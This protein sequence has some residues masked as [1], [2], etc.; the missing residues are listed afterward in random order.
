MTPN[1]AHPRVLV[2]IV[3]ILRLE[4]KNDYWQSVI[5]IEP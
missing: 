2:V 3:A 4:E 5:T 1:S